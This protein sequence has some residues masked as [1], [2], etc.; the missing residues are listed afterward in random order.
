VA[1]RRLREAVP[2]LT[3]GVKGTKAGKARRKIRR[4]TRALGT[5][6]ELDVTLHILDELAQ[7]ERVPRVAVEEVRAHVLAERD[8]RREVM[9]ERLDKIDP[10]KLGRRLTLV[11]GA[12]QQATTEGWREAL[13]S[14]LM[15]RAKNLTEA[16]TDAGQIYAPERLHEVRIA[17]K[18]LRYGLEIASETGIRTAAPMVRTLKRTQD[19]LGR[20]HDLQV[21][22]AHL[23]AVQAD[24]A[25]RRSLPNAALSTM[26]QVLEE[27]CRHLHGRYVSAVPALTEL[28]TATRA[29]IVPQLA[30][31]RRGGR[32]L[33]MALAPGTARKRAAGAAR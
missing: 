16:I 18:K 33:K 3:S 20:L 1:T 19:A 30:R 14:R 6:R 9:L 25:G 10:T 12:L 7:K 23:A 31:P 2:V 26:A 15:K 8:R 11:A 27:E 22:Q 29:T 24:A 17:A 5:V 28:A 4:L 13:A 21:L 32:P